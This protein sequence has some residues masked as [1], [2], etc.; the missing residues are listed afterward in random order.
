MSDAEI[1]EVVAFVKH[2]LPYLSPPS[3]QAM[4]AD[5]PPP[6]ESAPSAADPLSRALVR[7]LQAAA[8]SINTGARH[9]T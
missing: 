4:V 9:V 3:F 5:A 1:W 6:P 8:R 7:R 2:R